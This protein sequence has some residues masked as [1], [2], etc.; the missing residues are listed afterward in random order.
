MTIWIV[1]KSACIRSVFLDVD[2]AKTY[3]E[4]MYHGFTDW[5]YIPAD[6]T[7]PGEQVWIALNDT[8][9]HSLWSIEGHEV[10]E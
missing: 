6:E 5:E 4:Q 9:G 3:V 7:E 10:T 1:M 8:R 2:K